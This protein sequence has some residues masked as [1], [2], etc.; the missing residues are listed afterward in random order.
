MGDS[1]PA[2]NRVSCQSIQVYL[3]Y[4]QDLGLDDRALLE[5]L[6][7]PPAVLRDPDARVDYETFRTLSRR[8]TA[9]FP[10]DP[11]AAYRAGLSIPALGSLGYIAMLLAMRVEPAIIFSL[12]PRMVQRQFPMVRVTYERTAPTRC[13]LRYHH[14][15]GYE[16]FPELE[17][18]ARGLMEATPSMVGLPRAHVESYP[19][20][21]G[22]CLEVRWEAKG[23]LLPR[24]R[25]A[26][27]G[28]ISSLRGAATELE[29]AKDR[30]E[31]EID[32]A[33]RAA[34]RLEALLHIGRAVERGLEIA[35]LLER[36]AVAAN[37]TLFV[38]LIHVSVHDDP[39]DDPAWR[40]LATE[41]GESSSGL[42]PPIDLPAD[43]AVR[44]RFVHAL[45][46]QGQNGPMGLAF[47][48]A[49]DDLTRRSSVDRALL[50]DAFGRLGHALGNAYRHREIS[51]HG[52]KL[53]RE[54]ALRTSELAAQTEAL[55]ASNDKLLEV[56]R[57]KRRFFTHLSHELRTPA[58]LLSAS[59]EQLERETRSGE[60]A[61]RE[62]LTRARRNMAR[63]VYAVDDLLD[64][65]LLD[66]GRMSKASERVDV[67]ALV[68]SLTV[69]VSPWAAMHDV[70]VRERC[71]AE[72]VVLVGDRRLVEKAVLNLIANAVKFSP[73]GEA[74]EVVVDQDEDRVS[75]Q[76]L[77]RG[78]GINE[79][80]RNRIFEAFERAGHRGS[81]RGIG[82]GLSLVQSIASIHGGE[83]THAN[84]DPRGSS[85]SMWVPRGK[86]EDAKP[87]SPAIERVAAPAQRAEAMVAGAPDQTAS[88]SEAG[89]TPRSDT[90]DGVWDDGDRPM[91]LVVDDEAE[92][93]DVLRGRLVAN[94]RVVTA[95]SGTSALALVERERPEAVL[96]DVSMPGM[97]GFELCRRLR[98][99]PEM[100]QVPIVLL[101]A[102]GSVEDKLE[103]FD[104]GADDYVTKPFSLREVEARVRTHIQLRRLSAEMNAM[105]NASLMGSI[106]AGIVH[107]VNNPLNVL[108]NALPPVGEG[109]GEG[110]R[111]EVART[112]LD[113]AQDAARRIHECVS[114]LSSL[115]SWSARDPESVDLGELVASVVRQHR[116][117]GKGSTAI[118]VSGEVAC[119][120]GM[121]RTE[122]SLVI[123]NLVAN[124]IDAAGPDGRV[125]VI[126]GERSE[127]AT[128][129]IRDDGP[130]MDADTWRRA[131]EPFFT[132]KQ[133]GK[134]M[135]LGLFVVQQL[136]RHLEGRLEVVSK[137]GHGT[138]MTVVLP[139]ATT[140]RK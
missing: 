129:T 137:P 75:F 127:H 11:D 19:V 95:D 131:C 91:V 77:D 92:I 72:E 86:L 48:G 105:A 126:L 10:S 54:V 3:G 38:D 27:L 114:S 104:A 70:C 1:R 43:L 21:R 98:A 2:R 37:Q 90:V 32:Q 20:N 83:V 76:V 99:R 42:S 17:A 35:P 128:I 107:E 132:T 30:A 40:V 84:R 88:Q 136:L 57:A 94:Y 110:E 29:S 81:E 82:I 67:V 15:L 117:R 119:K 115:A 56:D 101:T 14:Q 65:A 134:G 44:S 64:L 60:P 23:H 116:Q 78:P 50:D 61:I 138:C 69:S 25:A 28:R 106:S 111:A 130:G 6:S 123:G 46:V 9:M 113:L 73:P 68:R 16:P 26:T 7:E 53:E 24:L 71:P 66:E 49:E 103:G 22:F 52:E 55:R 93:R 108:L 45:P 34:R 125:E 124:A 96:A 41:N 74:V 133:P 109:L 102:L 100:R 122:A 85:F 39:D 5:G 139:L 120:V 59:I 118:E 63:V 31:R 58:T 80:D 18:V 87:S 62:A 97:S 13:R 79:A 140:S 4:L 33:Q 135:G 51:T 36:F 47:V 12:T 121:L 89:P 112:M 8:F